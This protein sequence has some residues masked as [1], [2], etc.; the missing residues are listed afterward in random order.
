MTD[1]LSHSQSK[2]TRMCYVVLQFSMP[3]TFFGLGFYP[4][5]NTIDCRLFLRPHRGPPIESV[6]DSLTH[7]CSGSFIAHF[8]ILKPI[9]AAIS[10]IDMQPS[11]C[12]MFYY[13]LHVAMFLQPQPVPHRIQSQLYRQYG[14]QLQSKIEAPSVLCI[15]DFSQ[16]AVRFNP[17]GSHFYHSLIL[18]ILQNVITLIRIFFMFFETLIICM[19]M[20]ILFILNLSVIN[21]SKKFQSVIYTRYFVH[22]LYI[23]SQSTDILIY[24]Y[25]DTRIKY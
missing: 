11:D 15:L 12:V 5:Q 20:L 3:N 4:T 1:C 10:S 23:Y 13:M 21:S 22:N 17:L 14:M 16:V 7:Y 2:C 25:L 18:R 24:M 8:F 19:S 9:H 6:R